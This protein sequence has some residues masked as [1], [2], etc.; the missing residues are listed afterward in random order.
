M[1]HRPIRLLPP[2]LQNQIAA[3]EV[4]DRPAGALKEFVENSLDA[5]ATEISVTLEDGGLG[6]IAVRDNG[7]GIP[8]DELQLA[9]TRYATSKVASFSELLNV[10]SY[11]FRGEALASIG[12]VA[13]LTIE[14]VYRPK[15]VSSTAA[16]K[17]ACGASIRVRHGEI[18]PLRPCPIEQGTNVEVRDLFAN[19]PA[20]LKFLKSPPTELK[21]C[22]ESLIRSALVRTDVGFTLKVSGSG[23]RGNELL[24]L[25]A[26]LSLEERLAL[27]WPPQV[28]ASLVPFSG[29]QGDL[30]ARG[31]MSMPH[32]TQLRGDR[33][34]LYVNGR[35]VSNRVLFQAVREAYKGRL[36]SREYPQ[37]LLFLEINP[38]D[39][40]VN[41]HPAKN[42]VRFREERSIFNALIK[43]LKSS[44]AI[45]AYGHFS[46]TS[47]PDD[48]PDLF[49]EGQRRD[50]LLTPPG[51]EWNRNIVADNAP[52]YPEQCAF[53]SEDGE[54]FAAGSGS[55]TGVE[56]TQPFSGFD[57]EPGAGSQSI[58]DRRTERPAGFWGSIDKSRLLD[59]SNAQA[60]RS[61]PELLEEVFPAHP[62]SGALSG[63]AGQEIAPDGKHD[64]GYPVRIGDLVCLG[65]LAATYLILTHKDSLLLLDQ[66]AAHERMLLNSLRR[67]SEGYKSQLLI[68]P[69]KMLLHPS[70]KERYDAHVKK[71]TRMGYDLEIKE[72]LLY[73]KGT[74]P[75]LDLKASLRMLRDI[76]ADQTDGMDD[77]LHFMACRAAI[78]AG[79]RLSGD[80]AAG[81]LHSW[82]S[83][84]DRD[85][86]PHGRPAV[87]EF[88]ILDLEK[89]FK[90]KIA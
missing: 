90:R 46:A 6:L 65:Q 45:G 54:V 34:L 16:E 63:L 87:L 85:F 12:S 32:S 9:V 33:I 83:T 78:K 1:E 30:R 60:S 2:V 11:G 79:Q 13:D 4:V 36:T 47:A 89:M 8:G 84:S 86:C 88:N 15:F 41:V 68:F 25:P 58:P 28:V 71:F 57:G 42:E 72:N 20:R 48:G 22:R 14:S 80:E 64:D 81:L 50:E 77:I 40:D 10:T 17:K 66:H 27:I 3:G 55:R 7:A 18:S 69:E 62:S 73:V 52:L 49:A 59:R 44:K 35:P 70:E 24:R 67:D 61:Y 19:V 29:E 21:R 23:G 56:S 37:T 75:M 5:K 76:V 39:V 38:Q 26:G 74:P 43:I 53:P 31:L 51:S 82:L